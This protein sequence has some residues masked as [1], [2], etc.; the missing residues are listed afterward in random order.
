MRY[1]V[2]PS[3]KSGWVEQSE[4]WMPEWVVTDADKRVELAEF[5]AALVVVVPFV[6]L[7]L[8]YILTLTPAP[9]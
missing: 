2:R 6:G 7:F 1:R 5:L 3:V 4:P 8:V 9:R